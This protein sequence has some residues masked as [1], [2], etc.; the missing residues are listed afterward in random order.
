MDFQPPIWKNNMLVKFH[1]FHYKSGWKHPKIFELPPPRRWLGS[2]LGCQIPVVISV[3]TLKDTGPQS[4]FLQQIVHLL[5]FCSW[6]IC[7]K[8][9]DFGTLDLSDFS[10]RRKKSLAL[11]KNT[12]TIKT[13]PKFITFIS[14]QIKFRMHGLDI[15]PSYYMMW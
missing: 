4:I 6:E 12:L 1:H 8:L 5:I 13:I 9:I 15:Y 7:E 14:S 10:M 11:R 3:D 2:W